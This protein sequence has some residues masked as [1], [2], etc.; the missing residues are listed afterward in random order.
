M[1]EAG[2]LTLSNGVLSA[3]I[4]LPGSE[5][6]SERFDSAAVVQQITL[7]GRHRFGQPEQHIAERV[8]CYGFGLCA[9]YDMNAIGSQAAA[10][11]Y[12]PKPGVGLMRQMEDGLPYDMWRHYDIRRFPKR[13][14][15]GDDW[16]TFTEEPIPC[17]GVSLEITR[18]L[19]LEENRIVLTTSVRNAGERAVSFSE[20]QHNFVA[21]DDLPVGEG[22]CLELPFD[23]TIGDLQNCCRTLPDFQPAAG[24]I[25]VDGQKAFWHCR[26]KDQTWHKTTEAADI[27]P[28]ETYGWTLSH[29]DS[30]ASVSE[31]CGFKP[32]KL[33]L[34]G[35]EHCICTEVYHD[36]RLAPGETDT[37][38]RTWIFEDDE[39]RR[40][41]S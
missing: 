15:H 6:Q 24:F 13:W 10:G 19:R 39:T 7:H 27:L 5:P 30:D 28:C 18:K 29:R 17:L 25:T 11:A 2:V 4:R 38:T 8:T 16:I 35:V 34:W 36:I 22:Y 3:E 20:Y 12:F 21:I 31:R 40:D 26:V 41:A 37:Y 1:N 32:A 14:E 23:G 9:E 33:V